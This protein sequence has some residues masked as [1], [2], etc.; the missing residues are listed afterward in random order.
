MQS[1]TINKDA[2]A[3]TSTTLFQWEL[4]RKDIS[5]NDPDPIAYYVIVTDPAGVKTRSIYD[6]YDNLIR[7]EIFSDALGSFK[8]LNRNTFSGGLIDESL[9]YDYSDDLKQQVTTKAVYYDFGDWMQLSQIISGSGTT[10]ESL[11]DI[12][13]DSVS[14]GVIWKVTCRTLQNKYSDFDYNPDKP[15]TS[16]S[17]NYELDKMNNVLKV[18]Q[19]KQDGT[20]ISSATFKYDGLGRL[21]SA[22]DENSNTTEY[23]YDFLDRLLSTTRPDGSIIE[24]AYQ[25]VHEAPVKVTVKINK[26]DANGVVLGDRTLDGLGRVS[27]ATIGGRLYKYEFN[28]ATLLSPSKITRPDNA[29]L[30]F[31]YD[32]RLGN[33]PL[34]TLYRKTSADTATTLTSF[35]YDTKLGR[36]IGRSDF[37]SPEQTLKEEMTWNPRGELIKHVLRS[38]FGSTEAE[39]STCD[40]VYSPG[41]ILKA[42]TLSIGDSNITK[43]AWGLDKKGR[44]AIFT[45]TLSN[46]T[47]TYDVLNR[48]SACTNTSMNPMESFLDISSEYTYDDFD[49][50]LTTTYKQGSGKDLLTSVTCTFDLT[51]RVK[52]K[53]VTFASTSLNQ[54]AEYTYDNLDR[55]KQVDDIISNTKTLWTYTVLDNIEGQTTYNRTTGEV[56]SD[57]TYTYSLSDPCQLTSVK[58][59]LTGQETKMEFNPNGSLTSYGGV[60]I[61][62]DALERAINPGTGQLYYGADNSVRIRATSGKKMLVNYSGHEVTE[63]IDWDFATSRT[64]TLYSKTGH[65]NQAVYALEFNNVK[66][67]PRQDTT[68]AYG[69]VKANIVSDIGNLYV[70]TAVVNDTYFVGGSASFIAAD[71]PENISIAPDGDKLSVTSTEADDGIVVT[72]EISPQNVIA[73]GKSTETVTVTVKKDG[74]E[75]VGATVEFFAAAVDTT[76]QMIDNNSSVIAFLDADDN[77]WSV[78]YSPWGQFVSENPTEVPADA[79]SFNGEIPVEAVQGKVKENV[80][81][82]GNGYRIYRPAIM[83]FDKPDTESPFG[84]GG[85]NWY[86]YAGGDPINNLDPSGHA[87]AR[88]DPNKVYAKIVEAGGWISG[89][90]FTGG[91]P[92]FKP[93][94]L[95]PLSR[96][97]SVGSLEGPPEF[98]TTSTNPYVKKITGKIIAKKN[99]YKRIYFMPDWRRIKH[100]GKFIYGSRNASQ[101]KWMR[102][103]LDELNTLVGNSGGKYPNDTRIFS[104]SHG[105][106]NGRNF[107]F[108]TYM[109]S[110][111]DPKLSEPKFVRRAKHFIKTEGSRWPNLKLSVTNTSGMKARDAVTHY[112][113]SAYNIIHTFCYAANDHAMLAATGH[114]VEGVTLER[115]SWESLTKLNKLKTPNQNSSLLALL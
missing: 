49:N 80:Y 19:K 48:V 73:D 113:S 41:G 57:F 50:T 70:V 30:G 106:P 43:H 85:L 103:S 81:P 17:F 35:T 98:Y 94:K 25:S 15:I 69:Q 62:Y 63:H 111:R 11:Y 58:D 20:Q 108:D 3:Y 86:A 52:T 12:V 92:R 91:G 95:R 31:T 77:V 6:G 110:V 109:N 112:N 88:R 60:N 27:Q 33:A 51:D 100:N 10:E 82:L 78:P 90:L 65:N 99:T 59:I 26:D 34:S 75:L 84:A 18:S 24:Y 38:V 89:I 93:G 22:T 47:L 102:Q 23:E 45:N 115:D 36:L 76:R 9:E 96:N 1:V 101:P 42:S 44:P 67:T 54:N 61:T 39:R 4:S 56:V 66:I 14:G 29:E 71:S 16:G 5:D 28:S 53:K 40:Y 68:D 21:R 79:P 7:D 107:T 64:A 97:S 72:L 83:H 114:P 87:L 74:S 46:T 55:L 2:S 13:D 105:R 104:G 37:T 8:A 32:P